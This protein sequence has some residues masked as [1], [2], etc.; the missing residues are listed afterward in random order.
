MNNN[1]IIISTLIT[2]IFLSL[3]VQPVLAQYTE[4]DL[5]CAKKEVVIEVLNT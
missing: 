5:V 4:K 1:L 2:M 3:T